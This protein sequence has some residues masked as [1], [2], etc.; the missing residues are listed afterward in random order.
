MVKVEAALRGQAVA[1]APPDVAVL[2]EDVAHV[3]LGFVVEGVAPDPDRAADL[4]LAGA[5]LEHQV[6][7]HQVVFEVAR[8]EHVRPHGH[9]DFGRAH[10]NARRAV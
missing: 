2:H 4:E 6:A 9:F 5:V 8:V 1:V 10:G 3:V 7:H